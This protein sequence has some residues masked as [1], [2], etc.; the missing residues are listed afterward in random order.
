MIEVLKTLFTELKYL[1]SQGEENIYVDEGSMQIL[2]RLIAKNAKHKVKENDFVQELSFVDKID[3]AKIE[4]QSNKEKIKV[5]KLSDFNRKKLP[6]PKAFKLVGETKQDKWNSL[7]NIVLNDENCK[8]HLHKGKKLVFGI[9]NLDA[10]I[11]FCGEAP[12]AEEETQGEAFVGKAGQLLTKIIKAMGLERKD[13]YI[14]NIMSWRPE[15]PT[16]TGNRSP[17][18][19]EIAYC[20]P[21]LKA[22]IEIVKPKVIVALGNTAISGLLGADPK[23]KLGAIRGKW[24][25]YMQCHLMPTYHPSYL[26]QY[27][28]PATK[29]LVWEDMMM[30]MDKVGLPISEKQQS[31]FQ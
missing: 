8:E 27:A 13:V 29:R 26:I 17:E 16:L 1:K 2:N 15:M 24:L 5:T 7:K 6:E 4:T 19:D 20:L 18:A 28:T 25:E 23:R 21:Y 12:G 3:L 30:V 14:S 9:G 10:D 22:Q 31:Y 11:F